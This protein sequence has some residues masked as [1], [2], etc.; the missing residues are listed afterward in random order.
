MV[1]D[2][3]IY[4]E[5]PLRMLLDG[6]EDELNISGHYALVHLYEKHKE[7]FDY[8]VL[9]LRIGY[10]VIL[11]NSIFEL[12]KAFDADRFAFWIKELVKHAG[13]KNVNKNLVYII[14]DVLD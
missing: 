5:M 14:P 2:I 9:R 6:Y 1:G 8:S 7:Y 11:D 10:P 13:K 12:E 3:E 4:H